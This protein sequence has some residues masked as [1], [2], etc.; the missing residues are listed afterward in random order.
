MPDSGLYFTDHTV[1]SELE[2]VYLL[3]DF[4]ELMGY[5]VDDLVVTKMTWFYEQRWFFKHYFVVLETSDGSV[6]ATEKNDLGVVWS[7]LP[8]LTAKVKIEHDGSL[9][10]RS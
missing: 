5:S 1:V 8:S 6:F 10:P 2:K 7:Q 4:Y 3:T 9:T